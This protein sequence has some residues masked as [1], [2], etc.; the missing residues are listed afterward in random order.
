MKRIIVGMNEAQR[1]L[2]AAPSFFRHMGFG[3]DPT[4]T[5]M[6]Y[7]KDYYLTKEEGNLMK[8]HMAVLRA[9]PIKFTVETVTEGGLSNE[10]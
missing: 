1:K 4:D 5:I 2:Y 3:C 8:H 6:I 7:Y 10:R 9:I